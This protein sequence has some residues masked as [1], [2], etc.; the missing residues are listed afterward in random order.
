MLSPLLL[1]MLR[2][3]RRAGPSVAPQWAPCWAAALNAGAVQVQ[4]RQ[5]PA[6]KSL[7]HPQTVASRASGGHGGVALVRPA[8]KD[9]IDFELAEF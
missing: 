7:H 3:R 1:L 9:Q 8:K 6:E 4:G 5:G 2:R